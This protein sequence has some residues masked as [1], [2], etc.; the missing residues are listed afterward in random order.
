MKKYFF[1]AAAALVALASCSKVEPEDQNGP[2]ISFQTANYLNSTKADSD[3]HVE[4]YS[5]GKFNVAGYFTPGAWANLSGATAYMGNGASGSFVEISNVDGTWKNTTTPYYWPKAG[6][7][8]FIG[9]YPSSVSATVTGTNS[10]AVSFSNYSVAETLSSQASN[11]TTDATVVTDD[12]NDLMVADAIYDQTSNNSEDQHFKNGVAMIFHHTLAKIKFFAKQKTLEGIQADANL[13]LKVVINDL[14]VKAI[15]NIGSFNG[16]EWTPTAAVTTASG[17]F[18]TNA[19]PT[20]GVPYAGTPLTTDAVAQGS[21]YYVLPQ[22][23]SA[24]TKIVYI[25]YYVYTYDKND[26]NKV[27][28]V[29]MYQKNI[30][31]NTMEKSDKTKITSWDINKVYTYTITIDPFSGEIYFDP[32]V[33]DWTD[34][35]A[36]EVIEK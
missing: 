21:Q 31:L 3:G 4:F 34:A 14:Q 20:T 18:V 33:V 11:V 27:V 30:P 26:G 9:Y 7:L 36:A 25:K 32:A 17:A 13:P 5:A 16:S 12:K 1:F 24:D 22:N 10:L 28:D 23:L 35:D 2:E 8:S 19:A 6:K 15:N 29:Q